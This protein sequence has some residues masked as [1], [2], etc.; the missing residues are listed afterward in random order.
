MRAARALALVLIIV[1][2]ASLLAGLSYLVPGLFHRGRIIIRAYAM[3][4]DGDLTQLTNAS[5]S[6]W[7]WA[8]TPNGTEFIPVFNGTGPRP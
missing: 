7:A 5:F 1:V 2:S 8:P 4:S 3:G 6:V